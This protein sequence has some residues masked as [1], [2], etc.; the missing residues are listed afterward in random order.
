MGICCYFWGMILVSFLLRNKNKDADKSSNLLMAHDPDP[1]L[2]AIGA[3]LMKNESGV[4]NAEYGGKDLRVYYQTVPEI[5]WKLGIAIDES[6]IVAPVSSLTYALIA[7]ILITLAVI[8]CSVLLLARYFHTTIN[9]IDT[10]TNGAAAA[11]VLFVCF[12]RVLA[13]G[14]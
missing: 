2:A 10:F 7:I 5:G 11:I 3:A 13:Y 12:F 1:S 8:A 6:E 14:E 9:K 4:I